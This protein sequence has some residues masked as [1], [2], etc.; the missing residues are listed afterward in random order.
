ML[1]RLMKIVKRI[2]FIFFCLVF[3]TFLIN[4]PYFKP[5]FFPH[6]DT[7]YN[8]QIFYF[9]YNEYFFHHTM[10]QWIP[11]G[12]YGI[13]SAL[14]QLGFL[15]PADY[16][17]GFSGALLGV[18]N[19]LFLFKVATLLEQLTFLLGM[20]FLA[21]VLFK[22]RTIVLLVCIASFCSMEWCYQ[23]CFN[24]RL[25]EF[26]PFALYFLV[27]FFERRRAAY[28]WMACIMGVLWSLGSGFYFT[29]LFIF[30][31]FII[32][33]VLF[34]YYPGTWRYV[35]PRS[36]PDAGVMVL[37]F[38][39]AAAYLL[40]LKGSFEQIAILHRSSSS[41]A[42]NSLEMFL[43]YGRNASFG[44]VVTWFFSGTPVYT[45]LGAGR[46]NTVY[47]GF[48]TAV[49]FIW[50]VIFV[51][52]KYFMAVLAGFMALVWLS[53]GGI[54]ASLVYYFPGMKF[55]R[56][57][58]LVYPLVKICVVL[59]AGFGLAN[60]LEC[61][62]TI[63]MKRVI[64]TIGI[65]LLLLDTS[66]VFHYDMGLIISKVMIYFI[67]FLIWLCVRSVVMIKS[68]S[69]GHS[70][71]SLFLEHAFSIL[72]IGALCLDV[73]AFRKDLYD[74]WPKL[75]QK[76]L[77][78][79]K[80]VEVNE[81]PFVKQRGQEPAG[82]QALAFLLQKSSMDRFSAPYESI[83][84]FAQ[85]DPCNAMPDSGLLTNNMNDFLSLEFLNNDERDRIRG[86]STPK[87]RLLGGEKYFSNTKE[88]TDYMQSGIKF[89]GIALLQVPPKA[90]T[91]VSAG[92]KGY[93]Q[94]LGS[95][96]VMNFSANGLGM[97]TEIKKKDGAWLV[98]ADSFYPGWHAYVDGTS[99]AVYKAFTAFKAVFVAAGKH[100]V[101]FIFLNNQTFILSY[102]IAI[103]GL[104]AG[105]GSFLLLL[106]TLLCSFD[107]ERVK[108]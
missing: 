49:L 26:F 47:V 67:V 61:T 84:A 18:K 74:C 43:T 54:I 87:L 104:M 16:F 65:C 29:F 19:V 23:I 83:Y 22:R 108:E 59:G 5:S 20:Y 17:L 99:T 38:V 63:R 2:D 60:F 3:G 90:G 44:S 79:L 103:L 10:A 12:A 31:G 80:S 11:Y 39:L 66:Q 75:S 52:N 62:G 51:R 94:G 24:L 92:K 73:V 100:E 82:R 45:S 68:K 58:G 42:A 9:F 98:Y 102:I 1:I 76:A 70:I 50:S 93:A 25:Y 8:F 55:F 40:F 86:C 91:A 21:K 89:D 85:S 4:I 57:V 101:R 88:I 81:L 27:L 71:P 56:H 64:L 35:W 28:C 48:A 32:Y 46:D 95:I 15:T 36:R 37:F 6:H 34:A 77:A 107:L 96:S 69:T 13:P 14:F 72:L 33:A 97:W 41:G 105:A 53:F 30:L 7:L 78:G 106:I